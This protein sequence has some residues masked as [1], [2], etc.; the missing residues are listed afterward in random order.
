MDNAVQKPSVKKPVLCTAD[1]SLP[2]G[3]ETN[4]FSYYTVLETCIKQY[5]NKLLFS[6]K[7]ASEALG[8]SIEFLRKKINEG[9]INS[10]TLGDRKLISI[11]ELASIIHKGV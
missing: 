2:T 4:L 9:I 11:N 1:M 6:L 8:V 10:V 5:P 7:E 3:K